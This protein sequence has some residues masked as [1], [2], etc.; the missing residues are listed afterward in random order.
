MAL[1]LSEEKVGIT[2]AVVL[3]IIFFA[4]IIQ[5]LILGYF[6][7]FKVETF[8]EENAQYKVFV[9]NLP[10]RSERLNGFNQSYSLHTPYEIK[11]GING[12][13]LNIEH[14][15]EIGVLGTDL[16]NDIPSMGSI[17]CY[18]SHYEIWKQIVY[19]DIN[20]AIVFED[21]TIFEE[22][23]TENDI[24]SRILEL[25]ENWDIYIIGRPHTRL[26][27][28]KVNGSRDIVRVTTFYGSHAYVINKRGADKC[29]NN[30]KVFPIRKQIDQ[31]LS[32]FSRE[33]YINIY[34]HNNN[35]LLAHNDK[36]PSDVQSRQ[37]T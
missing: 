37:A 26:E 27:T 28:E 33:K 10:E 24:T 9:I 7:F 25:P 17:G 1:N 23:I 4:S 5:F 20:I 31:Q 35:Q 8:C 6:H 2:I 22:K 30:Q 15:K 34:M 13:L 19:E 12:N 16:D 21:D 32:D 3:V 18:L 29:I 11:K 14:L 36:Y